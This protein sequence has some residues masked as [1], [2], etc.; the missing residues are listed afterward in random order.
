MPAMN[1]LARAKMSSHLIF[2]SPSP[3]MRLLNF[4]P[5]TAALLQCETYSTKTTARGSS[6]KTPEPT[7]PKPEK[8][9]ATTSLISFSQI[10]LKQSEEL[11]AVWPK[12]GTISYQSKA[13]NFV[14]LIGRVGIPIRFES[15]GGGKHLAT[16]VISLMN[17]G[18]KDPLKIPVLFEGLLARVV[19]GHVRENDCVFVSGHLSVDPTDP[20]PNESESESE[21]L[22][23]FHVV[24]E[25]INFVVG[26][27][28]NSLYGLGTD[29]SVENAANG[30]DEL[31]KREK[32]E[33]DEP[34][35]QTAV[36][37]SGNGDGKKKDVDK[38]MDLWRD[39][40]KNPLQ[41]W[42]FREHKA[43]G[44]VKANHPDFKQKVNEEPLWIKNAPKW[45]LP[46]IVKLEFEVKNMRPKQNKTD[47]SW[48]EL[49]ENLD[50]WWDNRATKRNPKAPDFVHKV[51]SKVDFA[52]I[53]RSM[54]LLLIEAQK[55]N[56][57][58]MDERESE[59]KKTTFQE[60][61]DKT[62]IK[63]KDAKRLLIVVT[64]TSTRNKLRL[65]FY[66]HGFIDEIKAVE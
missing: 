22:G 57:S 14:N 9:S 47:D 6:R 56:R 55:A 38:A 17:G 24:A 8:R 34:L 35:A 21:S 11:T 18:V 49:V 64:P 7:K 29:K 63:E 15:A 40:V 20:V 46:E 45:I 51:T 5:K 62:E 41:W 61:I 33:D 59:S 42:D 50:D 27:E 31:P 12:P 4:H 25:N 66:D 10:A 44:L 32:T 60:E 43:N 58:L 36:P 19:S 30:F 54:Q 3:A 16:T 1:V 28:K 48:K 39:L 2:S 26:L 37:E 23:K 65:E 13:A 52:L 53:L